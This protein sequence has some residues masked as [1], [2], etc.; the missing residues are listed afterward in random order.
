MGYSQLLGINLFI[1]KAQVNRI[2]ERL[3]KLDKRLDSL[4]DFRQILQHD[5]QNKSVSKD[6]RKQLFLQA[7]PWLLA[8][9]VAVAAFGYELYRAASPTQRATIQELQDA[10]GISEE[11]VKMVSNR[12]TAGYTPLAHSRDFLDA[13][14]CFVSYSCFPPT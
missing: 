12:R 5:E 7:V 11:K 3:D 1:S 9:S 4:E 10:L 8:A 2:I 14:R 13:N 6:F